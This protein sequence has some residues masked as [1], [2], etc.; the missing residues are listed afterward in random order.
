MALEPIQV[1]SVTLDPVLVLLGL[2][3]FAAFALL[4]LVVIVA[5][6]MSRRRREAHE[7]D[8]QLVELKVRLQTLAEIANPAR[9]ALV[10]Y[11]MPAGILRQLKRSGVSRRRHAPV[12][13]RGGQAVAARKGRRVGGRR[14]YQFRPAAGANG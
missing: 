12:R 7:S 6:H 9:T 14:N 3:G 2:L 10:I 13:A 4:G 5:V 11:D 1:G 8:A